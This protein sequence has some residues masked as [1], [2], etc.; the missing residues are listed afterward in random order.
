[1]SDRAWC[2]RWLRAA[3][4]ALAVLAT[5]AAAADPDEAP[6]AGIVGEGMTLPGGLWIAGDVT[7]AVEV[8]EREETAAEI[9][10]VSLLARWEPA[11]RFALF[12]EL[13]LED[14]AEIVED[15][16]WTTED[17]A[18][19]IERLWAEALLTPALAVRIGKTFT[20]FGLWNQI[21]RAPF[22][23][24]VEEPAVADELFPVHATGVQLLYRT[25]WRGWSLDATAYG[26]AQDAIRLPGTEPEEGW[27]AGSR[28]A[29]GRT[30]GPAFGAIGVNAAGFRPYD[31]GWTVA[32]GLD[33][34]VS[35]A[36]HQVSGE[37][38]FQIPQDGRRTV[39]GFYLQD[40]IPLEPVSPLARNLYAVAR[41]ELL[42]PRRGGTAV[43][44]LLGVFWRPRP[45]LVLRAD[46]LFATHPPIERLPPGFHASVSLLF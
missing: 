2:A 7:V 15:E 37:L 27:L 31:G 29:V 30:V 3:L 21:H 10:D 32:T 8:P 34:E 22:T 12:G 26:P 41:V 46:Y 9:D 43:G 17:A 23:W 36:G 14:A 24:T 18:F 33:L 19:T 44:G 28:V 25:T 42:Q 1:M 20:P 6:A 40:A 16:G 45:W 11:P 5:T 39:Y 35:V 4:L 38:T 13:R